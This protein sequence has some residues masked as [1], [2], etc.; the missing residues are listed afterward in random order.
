M[1]ELFPD[2]LG[3]RNFLVAALWKL[4]RYDEAFEQYRQ[5]WGEDDDFIGTLERGY[6]EAGPEGAMRARG[7]QLAAMA[8]SEPVDPIVVA[9]YYASAGDVEP[10]FEWLERAF[11]TRDPQILH[12]PF[13]PRYESLHS[14]PRYDDLLRRIGLPR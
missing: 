4:G 3:T 2:S 1:L 10:A 5:G 7:E 13:D 14:D 11:E 9:R 12:M 6:A 8:E